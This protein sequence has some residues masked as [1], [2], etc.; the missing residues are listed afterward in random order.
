MNKLTNLCRSQ[1]KKFFFFEAVV[2]VWD[3]EVWKSWKRARPQGP[4]MCVSL[5]RMGGIWG[6]GE[7]ALHQCWEEKNKL[8][9]IPRTQLAFPRTEQGM[10]SLSECLFSK[11]E[12]THWKTRLLHKCSR[13]CFNQKKSIMRSSGSGSPSLFWGVSGSISSACLNCGQRPVHCMCSR[14]RVLCSVK[15]LVFCISA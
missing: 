13:N 9:R 7:G 3:W 2:D 10:L 12:N 14:E 11:K 15:K 6:T 1:K 4:V 8:L 5:T